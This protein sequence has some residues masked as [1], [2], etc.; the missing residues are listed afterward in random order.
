MN[1]ANLPTSQ[2]ATLIMMFILC[3]LTLVK[4]LILLQCYV[5]LST[6]QT[7]FRLER[8]AISL[9]QREIMTRLASI[10]ICVDVVPQGVN[11]AV[12]K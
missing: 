7:D 11:K 6:I 2:Y 5:M 12:E 10:E 9:R 8:E 3:A 1:N 4:M